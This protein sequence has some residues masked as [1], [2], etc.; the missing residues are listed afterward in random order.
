MAADIYDVKIPLEETVNGDFA[1]VSGEELVRQRVL[2]G[3][4]TSPGHFHDLPDWGAELEA[5]LNQ[6]PR[7]ATL[8]RLRNRARRF[9]DALPLIEGYTVTVERSDSDT[10]LVNTRVRYQGRDVQLPEVSLA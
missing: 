3:Y 8:A 2:L 7:P 5:E 4:R 9:L 1:V 6:R 10:I